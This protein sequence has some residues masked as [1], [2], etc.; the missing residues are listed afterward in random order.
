MNCIKAALTL[1]LP[2]KM[3]IKKYTK[4]DDKFFNALK[5]IGALGAF[6]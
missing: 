5:S 3:L 2:L 1:F 4:K 6:F